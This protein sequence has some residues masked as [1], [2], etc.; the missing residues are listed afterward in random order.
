MLLQ[1]PEGGNLQ[2]APSVSATAHLAPRRQPRHEHGLG[3]G[4][5]EEAALASSGAGTQRS[6]GRGVFANFHPPS[7]SCGASRPSPR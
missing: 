7:P 3:E 4:Q 2:S 5:R 6:K 1:G